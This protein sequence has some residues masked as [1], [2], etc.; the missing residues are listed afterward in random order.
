MTIIG[1]PASN[2]VH[3][4]R[5]HL[6]RQVSRR[7][8]VDPG[9]GALKPEI[10]RPKLPRPPSTDRVAPD[11]CR[12][13]V[14]RRVVRRV[15]TVLGVEGPNRRRV[16]IL[17]RRIVPETYTPA[18]CVQRPIGL[19]SNRS[20]CTCAVP[21][22]STFTSAVF[23]TRARPPLVNSTMP[24]NLKPTIRTEGRPQFDPRCGTSCSP[25]RERR[26][27]PSPNRRAPATCFRRVQSSP[28][29]LE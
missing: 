4:V 13:R 17:P 21:S 2:Q 23:R 28:A 9:G 20:T 15:D 3:A 10:R 14:V 8:D 12:R 16:L 25:C 26:L 24:W 6:L 1:L 27:A 11:E 22:G 5:S 29:P 7:G 18:P 19:T